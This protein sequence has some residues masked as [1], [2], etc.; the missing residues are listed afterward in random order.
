M[1][2]T[3][4][5]IPIRDLLRP[6]APGRLRRPGGKADLLIEMPVSATPKVCKHRLTPPVAPNGVEQGKVYGQS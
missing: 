3:R 1:H 5:D 4:G 6:Y 2:Y